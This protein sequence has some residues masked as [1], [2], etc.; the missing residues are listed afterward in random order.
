MYSHLHRSITLLTL[1]FIF[2]FTQ[3]IAAADD[4]S[5]RGDLRANIVESMNQFIQRQT[6]NGQFYLYDA[7]DGQMLDLEFVT[8]H[9]G[10]VNKA[11]FYVSCADFE[12]QHGR[13][14]DVDFLV[15][16]AQGKLITTQAVVHSV[17]GH[18]RKYHLE[19]R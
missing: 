13:N 15:R 1:F 9:K 7:V 18:K 5:I 19:S 10:I 11:G 3:P 16:P 14:V 8:L 12:D 4:P 2:S 17:D 6:I